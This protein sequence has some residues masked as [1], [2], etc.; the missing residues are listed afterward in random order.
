MTP[1]FS[2]SSTA[3]PEKVTLSS[4]EFLSNVDMFHTEW[5]G[6]NDHDVS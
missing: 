3:P 6:D 4:D 5:F 2:S 1:S